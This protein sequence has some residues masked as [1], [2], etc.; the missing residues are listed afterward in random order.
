[1]ILVAGATGELGR[2]ICQKL[3]ERGGMVYGMVRAG[4]SP[5]AVAELEAMGVV[6]VQAELGN[7][8]SLREACS[9]CDS[10][11]SGMTAMGRASESIERVDRDGQ[12]ALVAAAAEE[13]VE[14]FV[15]VS[16]SG[17]IGKDDPLTLAKRA[18]E[19]TLKHS[20]MTWTVLRPSYFMESWFS[21]ALGFDIAAGKARIYG[22]GREPISWVAREDVAE[23]AAAA[24][25][26]E[27]ARNATIEIGGPEA[28]APLDAVALFESLAGRPIEV[29]TIDE[30]TLRAQLAAARTEH[31]RSMASVMLAYAKGN[32][33]PMDDVAERF[34]V[35][36]TRLRQWAERLLGAGV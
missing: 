19:R 30:A 7:R 20:G 25:D 5:A 17:V 12:L 9:G 35:E 15:Y 16:Y 26:S 36:P 21:P 10:V 1:M 4:S 24:V 31:E 8:E 27:E 3:T 14:R 6:P 23:F 32:A 18:V 11:V 13:G 28:I 22:A 2:V 34:G 33:I 29:E